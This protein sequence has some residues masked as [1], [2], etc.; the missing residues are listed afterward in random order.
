MA[1]LILFDD[2]GGRLGPMRDLRAAFELRTG[3]L[4]TAQRL[5][6]QTGDEPVALRVP[7]ELAELVASRW[8]VPVN[9]LPDDAPETLTLIN[10][11]WSRLEYRLPRMPGTAVQDRY[12][13]LLAACVD[14]DTAGAFLRDGVADLGRGGGHG[15]VDTDA[16]LDRPWHA[17]RQ[18]EANPAVDFSLF[19][20]TPGDFAGEPDGHATLLGDHPVR[21]GQ[22]VRIASHVVL[23]ATAGPIVIDD[24]AELNAFTLVK[25]PAY[26]GPD[27]IVQPHSY[28]R[29]P[30]AFGPHCRIGGEIKHVIFQSYSNKNHEGFV[31]DSF[32]GEWVNLGAGTTTSNL[33]NTYGPVRMKL[34]P[35]GDA[36]LTG[37]RSLG[38][39]VGDHVRTA[40]GTRLPTGACLG[41]GAMLALSGFPAKCV[42]PFS[43]LTDRAATVYE[44]DKFC[45]VAETVMARRDQ[46]L[47]PALRR[48]LRHLYDS[49]DQAD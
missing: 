11:R 9:A 40:I 36:E 49:I 16:L 44:F 29:G 8:S 39:I 47:R 33:K 27:C 42:P 7:E 25:G 4:T 13:T 30:V 17:L 21:F 26:F 23:D 34:T 6:R 12:G 22:D 1:G 28:I 35:D 3:A 5:I 38:A 15:A 20:E 19:A 24:S 10:G 45:E 31:G 37:L 46:T 32:I 18:L 2:D 41:L 14:R 43:F 48:R